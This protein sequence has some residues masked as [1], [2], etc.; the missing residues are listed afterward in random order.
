MQPHFAVTA[1]NLMQEV[2]KTFFFSHLYCNRM[3]LIRR[4]QNELDVVANI[5]MI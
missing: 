4:K 1:V 3:L 5:C 2:I